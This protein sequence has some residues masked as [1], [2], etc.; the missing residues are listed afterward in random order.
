MERYWNIEP[1]QVGIRYKNLSRRK[2]TSMMKNETTKAI[3][4]FLEIVLPKIPIAVYAAPIR[5]SPMYPAI[6]EPQSGEPMK[7]IIIA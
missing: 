2:K 4:W 3:I 1:S 5:K 7:E 6:I